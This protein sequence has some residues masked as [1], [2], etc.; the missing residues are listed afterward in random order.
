MNAVRTSIGNSRV[1]MPPQVATMLK[2]VPDWLYPFVEVIDGDIVRE[3]I[4]ERETRVDSWQDATVSEEPIV[5]RD[6]PIYGW[7]PG[8]IIGPYVL[9]GWGPREVAAEQGRRE[10]QQMSVA[11]DRARKVAAWRAPWFAGAAAA[12]TLIAMVLLATSLRGQGG[13]VFAALATMAAIGA[14]WQSTH[15]FLTARGRGANAAVA[16]HF[17]TASIGSQILLALWLVA[18]W[19]MAMSWVTPVVLLIAAAVCFTIGRRFV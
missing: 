15:D 11:L 19:Y 18:R 17:L 16:A 14:A 6:E 7:E 1:V 3:R 5:V 2:H 9:T 8:V 10:S 4:I 12:M 13:G